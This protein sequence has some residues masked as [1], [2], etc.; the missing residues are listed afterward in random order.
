MRAH[1]IGNN[2]IARI[3][4][5][6]MLVDKLKEVCDR[7]SIGCGVVSGIGATDSFVCGVFDPST[8]HY[9]ELVFEGTYEILSLCGNITRMNN[10]PYIHLHITAGDEQG[11]CIG[12][13]LITAR[14]SATCEIIINVM[15]S[16]VER[17]RDENTALNLLDI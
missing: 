17:Y 14:I 2:I 4:R 5:G 11:S 13:H 9:K 12:G 8:K 1:K 3:D 6:E 15:D 10:K 7:F 16:T